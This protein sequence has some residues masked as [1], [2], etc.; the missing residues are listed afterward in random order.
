[1]LGGETCDLSR[2]LSKTRFL[3]LRADGEA[4]SVDEFHIGH[5]EEAQEVAHI[6]GLRVHRRARIEA[7]ARRKHVHF[8]AGQLAY[9]TL[10]RV[11]EGD[12]GAGDVIEVG[13]QLRR[14]PEVI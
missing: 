12:T 10:L 7:A 8:L 4:F 1:M 11:L 6:A 13:L 9:R 3:T 5:A 2:G 14:Y